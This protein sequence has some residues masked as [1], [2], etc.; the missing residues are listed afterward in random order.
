M[1]AARTVDSIVMTATWIWFLVGTLVFFVV[2]GVLVG[3]AFWQNERHR[4]DLVDAGLVEKNEFLFPP[5]ESPQSDGS[6]TRS[7]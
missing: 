2:A 5:P 3:L 1:F 6:D 7:E 4:F